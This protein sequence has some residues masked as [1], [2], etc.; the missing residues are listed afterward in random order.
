MAYKE[1]LNLHTVSLE[2]IKC[3]ATRLRSFPDVLSWFSTCKHM[4]KLYTTTISWTTLCIGAIPVDP[5]FPFPHEFFQQSSDS[6]ADWMVHVRPE[7]GQEFATLFRILEC[8]Q[9]SSSLL[10]RLRQVKFLFV[11]PIRMGRRNVE[12]DPVLRF[13]WRCD[14]YDRSLPG[15]SNIQDYD[16]KLS[17]FDF[18][19]PVPVFTREIVAACC[20]SLSSVQVLHVYHHWLGHRMDVR[21][22]P[23]TPSCSCCSSLVVFGN[24]CGL[25]FPVCPNTNI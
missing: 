3:I 18:I 17:M 9:Q 5:T 19:D 22:V 25:Y 6:P 12:L 20:L 23:H 21:W 1:Y 14:A 15:S 7:L 11:F 2:V 4:R 16:G 10:V 13:P 24:N 8:A